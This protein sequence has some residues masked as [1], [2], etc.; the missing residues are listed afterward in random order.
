MDVEPEEPA[1]DDEVPVVI[2]RTT[3]ISFPDGLTGLTLAAQARLAAANL[4]GRDAT[5]EVFGIHKGRFVTTSGAARMF[6]RPTTTLPR[7]ASR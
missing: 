7:R 2:P 4:R 6:R 1:D 5:K 3:G